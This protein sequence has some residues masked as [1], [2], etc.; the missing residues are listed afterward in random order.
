MTPARSPYASA[1]DLPIPGLTT[2]TYFAAAFFVL[3]LVTDIAYLQTTVLMWKDF[4]SWLLFFGLIAGGIAVL[5]WLID[6]AVHRH[7]PMAGVVVLN[8]AILICAVLNSLLH[9][10]DGWT[11]ILP[12]GVGLSAL[13]CL[14]MVASALLRRRAV[15]HRPYV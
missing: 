13:T 3:T 2:F 11:A 10:G 6:L 15:A 8:V 14:L 5:L 7:R 12:W 9:A 1:Y 4:S